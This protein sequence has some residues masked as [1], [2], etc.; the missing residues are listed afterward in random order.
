MGSGRGG[1]F[2]EG[3]VRRYSIE[4][5]GVIQLVECQLPKLDVAGSSP[6]ARSGRFHSIPLCDEPLQPQ[7]WRGSD[8]CWTEMVV[9]GQAWVPEFPSRATRILT[10]ERI[11]AKARRRRDP[12]AHEQIHAA[13]ARQ[14]RPGPAAHLSAEA[15]CCRFVSLCDVNLTGELT[16]PDQPNRPFPNLRR[17]PPRFCHAPSLSLLRLS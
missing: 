3:G 16:L 11:G 10:T 12:A 9:N 6:V 5:A 13:A 8:V 4:H 1:D 2:A 15:N 17:K 7:G 14:P